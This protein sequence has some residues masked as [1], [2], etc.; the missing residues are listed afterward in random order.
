MVGGADE[1]SQSPPQRSL[2]SATGW[3]QA[4]SLWSTATQSRRTASGHGGLSHDGEVSRAAALAR[5]T[6]ITKRNLS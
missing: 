1:A 6:E 3:R 2:Q 5:Q 4:A